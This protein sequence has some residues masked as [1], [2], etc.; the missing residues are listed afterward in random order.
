MRRGW[1]L[2]L[3]LVAASAGAQ[4]RIVLEEVLASWQGD[5]RV[6]FVELR[7]LADGQ[8]A[9]GNR[10]ELVFDDE[11]ASVDGRRF[12][13]ITRDAGRG[14]A[15][16]AILVATA[17]LAELA[18]VTPDFVL[19]PGFLRPVGGRVCWQVL[20]AQGAVRVI[21]CV[22]WG[23]FRGPTFGGGRPTRLT[24]DNRSLQRTAL[25]G[26]IRQ[27]WT[28][29]LEP[30]PEN[31]AGQSARLPTLCGDG[32]ISQ[33]EQC[34]GTR[35]GGA[36]CASLGFARGKLLC[37]Q[38]HYDTRKCTRCGN[39]EIDGGESCD[40]TDLGE[41]T[42]E[43]LGFTGGTLGCSDRCTL[44]TRGCDETFRLPG[45]GPPRAD[46]QAE[47]LV[48]H[49]GARPDGSGKAPPRLVCR[50]GDPACDT[51]GVP[52]S[53]TLPVRVCLGVADG[54]LPRCTPGATTRWVLRTPRDTELSRVLLSA[55]ARL[56][57]G[58]AGPGEVQFPTPV[59]PES[60]CSEAVDVVVPARGR[61]VLRAETVGT[62]GGR[63]DPDVLRL[64]CLP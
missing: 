4:D 14:V 38:C 13:T 61:A 21:D 36:T 19:P 55:V 27:D 8:Q 20:D 29:Q 10:A 32:A 44:D 30:T 17:R 16:A 18:R 22:A 58:V 64:V 31:N 6:Q 25:S 53:C 49:G 1:G 57:D 46:C 9:V 54:R 24:P 12:F 3:A 37:T 26:V 2:V 45:G 50:D 33:G 43:G 23:T 15:G 51:G 5:D 35:L 62:A 11:T 40:G 56:G 34:D 52:G 59:P 42:C 39:D 63:G 60:R 41:A 48:R 47:W 7:M 28:G